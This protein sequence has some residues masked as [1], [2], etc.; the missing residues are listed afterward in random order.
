M[1]AIT[2]FILRNIFFFKLEI[3]ITELSHILRTGKWPSGSFLPPTSNPLSR[4]TGSVR[5]HTL[6]H[7]HTPFSKRRGLRVSLEHRCLLMTTS[8]QLT[9]EDRQLLGDSNHSWGTIVPQNGSAHV[10]LQGAGLPRTSC[11]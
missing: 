7:T 1:I 10:S 11:E 5:K 8:C 6:T 3:K 9:Q 4:N 2:G